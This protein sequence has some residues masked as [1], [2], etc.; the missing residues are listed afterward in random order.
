M[1]E[2]RSKISD[3]Q[4]VGDWYINQMLQMVDPKKYDKLPDASTVKIKTKN[5]DGKEVET[6]LDKTGLKGRVIAYKDPATGDVRSALSDIELNALGL[7]FNAGK[8]GITVAKPETVIYNTDNPADPYFIASYELNINGKVRKETKII[9]P[10]VALEGLIKGVV[11]ESTAGTENSD[12]KTT[13]RRWKERTGKEN[14]NGSV[15]S[16][17]EKPEFQATKTEKQK[18]KDA[19]E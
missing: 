3:K 17:L 8:D 2:I 4:A 6:T 5:K 16:E 11:G 19:F 10:N 15:M 9:R 13:M 12:F 14:I 1:K 18:A 7:R